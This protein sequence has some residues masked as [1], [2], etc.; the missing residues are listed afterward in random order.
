MEMAKTILN[1]LEKYKEK[2]I[3]EIFEWINLDKRIKKED[4]GIDTI[5][6]ADFVYGC[7]GTFGY[8]ENMQ[9]FTMVLGITND[10]YY[11]YMEIIIKYTENG[12]PKGMELLFN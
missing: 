10:E 8:K 3:K 9:G 11:G 6:F 12:W 1:D 2:S 4:F 5:T 7:Q